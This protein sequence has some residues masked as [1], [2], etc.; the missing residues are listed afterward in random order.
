M[1]GHLPV[2]ISFLGIWFFSIL[3]WFISC[4]NPRL[5]LSCLQGRVCYVR[6]CQLVCMYSLC[7]CHYN[8]LYHSLQMSQ[9][10]IQDFWDVGYQYQRLER[11]FIIW[12]ICDQKLQENESNWT[13]MGST[14]PKHPLGSTTDFVCIF[15]SFYVCLSLYL[16]LSLSLST[17]LLLHGFWEKCPNDRLTPAAAWRCLPRKPRFAAQY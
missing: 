2:W 8:F 7:V 17:I 6:G 11:Q 14:F 15:L 9:W 5:F 16:Y 4:S 10:R 12:Q 1:S 3:L 13:D